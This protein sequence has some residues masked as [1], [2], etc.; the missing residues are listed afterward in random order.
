MRSDGRTIEQERRACTTLELES[1]VSF[2]LSFSTQ[3]L[4]EVT[5]YDHEGTGREREK[6]RSNAHMAKTKVQSKTQGCRVGTIGTLFTGERIE[7]ILGNTR[8]M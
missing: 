5:N 2:V 3:H 7:V 8:S 6:R 4:H 1:L